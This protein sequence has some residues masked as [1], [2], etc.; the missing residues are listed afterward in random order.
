M[1]VPN[2]IKNQVDSQR[3]RRPGCLL[4]VL[5]AAAAPA[6]EWPNDVSGVD[7]KCTEDR[8]ADVPGGISSNRSSS[9]PNG[10]PAPISGKS[11]AADPLPPAGF[12]VFAG[13]PEDAA[14]EIAEPDAF[15]PDAARLTPDAEGD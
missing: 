9:K 15:G 2:K 14:R 6:L 13:T 1:P 3:L 4:L 8:G 7:A 12:D 5:L 11:L 10:S